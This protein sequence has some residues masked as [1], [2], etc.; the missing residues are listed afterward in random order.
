MKKSFFR[1]VAFGLSPNDTTP[2]DPLAWAQSQFDS[3]P[4]ILWP[5]EVESLDVLTELHGDYTNASIELIDKNFES[6][7]DYDQAEQRLWS[8]YRLEELENNEL[9]IRHYNEVG[10]YMAVH[11]YLMMPSKKKLDVVKQ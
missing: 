1:K 7:E 8:H 5:N 4:E 3:I 9:K 10:N 2:K 11:N 6:F